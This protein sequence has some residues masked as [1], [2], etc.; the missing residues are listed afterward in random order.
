MSEFAGS[1]FSAQFRLRTL[2]DPEGV[3]IIRIDGDFVH[4]RIRQLFV[5]VEVPVGSVH[6]V[7]VELAVYLFYIQAVFIVHSAVNETQLLKSFCQIGLICADGSGCF[8]VTYL[9]FLQELEIRTDSGIPD[10][11]CLQRR[12]GRW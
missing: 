9:L 3:G 1:V 5:Y 11:E 7:H 10:S 2:T 12:S 6:G 4:I 8:L